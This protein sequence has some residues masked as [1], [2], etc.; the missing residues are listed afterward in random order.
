MRGKQNMATPENLRQSIVGRR[1]SYQDAIQKEKYIREH[2]RTGD[3]IGYGWVRINSDGSRTPIS[4]TE[5]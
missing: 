3:D 5:L 1:F 4:G 2:E